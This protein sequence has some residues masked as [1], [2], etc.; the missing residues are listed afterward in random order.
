MPAHVCNLSIQEV[1]TISCS[2]GL[3]SELQEN[4]RN[5]K[6]EGNMQSVQDSLPKGSFVSK[7]CTL[8]SFEGLTDS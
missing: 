3:P 5:V 7:V 8:S 1:E 6:K 2:P 4:L